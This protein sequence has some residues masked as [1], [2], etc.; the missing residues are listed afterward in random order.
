MTS[1]SVLA[2]PPPMVGT[3]SS[4]LGKRLHSRLNQGVGSAEYS[5]PMMVFTSKKD[6]SCTNTRFG[7]AR[8]SLA[9]N[10]G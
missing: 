9:P 3:Y 5:L 8:L 2:V 6:S 1:N 4:P 7:W 10:T